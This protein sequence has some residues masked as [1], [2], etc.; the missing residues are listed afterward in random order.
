[1]RAGAHGTGGVPTWSPCPTETVPVLTGIAG[2]GTFRDSHRSTIND[3]SAVTAWG[4]RRFSRLL[5]FFLVGFKSTR[6]EALRSNSPST[7]S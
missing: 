6:P 5:Y 1:M 2:R 4:Y 7:Q 3:E